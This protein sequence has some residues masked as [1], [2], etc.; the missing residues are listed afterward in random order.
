MVPERA[1]MLIMETKME[2]S[3]KPSASPIWPMLFITAKPVP[4]PHKNDKNNTQKSTVNAS[5]NMVWSSPSTGLLFSI[6]PWFFSSSF[7]SVG[8]G[9]NSLSA[10]AAAPTTVSS[11][12]SDLSKGSSTRPSAISDLSKDLN[13]ERR[14]GKGRR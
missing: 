8:D 5:Y 13:S 9:G 6:P 4:T 11:A 2:T 7:R 3:V 12:I 1:Q 14:R 10:A